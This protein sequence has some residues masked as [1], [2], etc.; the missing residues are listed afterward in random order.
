MYMNIQ[1]SAVVSK[2]EPRHRKQQ[3]RSFNSAGNETR[4]R[5]GGMVLRP[6]SE[7]GENRRAGSKAP[8][9]PLPGMLP[10]ANVPVCPHVT[11]RSAVLA[12]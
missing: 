6:E 11:P 7:W 12:V 2:W 1:R 5:E 9:L 3:T 8:T 4:L 10:P